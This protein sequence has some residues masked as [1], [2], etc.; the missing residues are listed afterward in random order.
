MNSVVPVKLVVVMEQGI[1]TAVEMW[2]I[3]H[4]IHSVTAAQ[5]ISGVTTKTTILPRLCAATRC[6]RYAMEERTQNAVGKRVIIGE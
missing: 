2:R 6:W 4:A 3:T 5:F 1:P